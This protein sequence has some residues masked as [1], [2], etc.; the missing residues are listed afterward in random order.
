M[1]LRFLL[2]CVLEVVATA[3][4]LPPMAFKSPDDT[5]QVA[6][7]RDEEAIVLVKAHM[8]EFSF[9]PYEI[10]RARMPGYTR[11]PLCSSRPR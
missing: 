11:K 9:S 2:V 10:V 5:F 7:I 6:C 1:E 4:A 8:T 3:C